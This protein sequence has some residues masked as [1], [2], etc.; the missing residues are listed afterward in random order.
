MTRVLSRKP[1]TVH[2]DPRDSIASG[3]GRFLLLR[4]AS[5]TC[6]L[7]L[8]AVIEVMRRLPVRPVPDMTRFHEG[9]SNVRGRPT[10]VVSL[11][12]LLGEDP[13][14]EPLF[15]ALRTD[16]RAVVVAADGVHGV[17]P[18]DVQMLAEASRLPDCAVSDIVDTIAARDED[19]LLALRVAR[20]AN[21]DFS[22]ELAPV[23]ARMKRDE[24]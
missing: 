23:G 6:A 9:V 8:E 1:A 15:V 17:E 11:R 21:D 14:E 18:L 22:L 3:P 12:K 20:I 16:A 10:A 4:C 7:P 24:D 5:K 19:L 13:A 2:G